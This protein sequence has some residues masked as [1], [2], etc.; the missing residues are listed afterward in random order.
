MNLKK[1]AEVSTYT[2]DELTEGM[3]AHYT[4]MLGGREVG[5]FAGTSGDLSP[6][7]VDEEFG[8]NSEFGSNLVHGM[9]IAS[10]FSTLIGVHLPGRNALLAGIDFAFEKPVPVGSEVTVS[11]SILA[12]QKANRMVKLNLLAYWNR[13]IC[14]RGTASVKI[15]NDLSNRPAQSESST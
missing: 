8:K 12:V 7:H 9:L 1:S 11:A 4:V 5:Q 15:Q 10:H 13:E 6:L 2:L 14:V 3:S